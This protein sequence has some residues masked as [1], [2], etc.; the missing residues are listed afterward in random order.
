MTQDVRIAR[1]TDQMSLGATATRVKLWQKRTSNP[2][3]IKWTNTHICYK[4]SGVKCG[5]YRND[6]SFNLRNLLNKDTWTRITR[7]QERVKLKGGI[8]RTCKTINSFPGFRTTW[9]RTTTQEY[10]GKATRQ[11]IDFLSGGGSSGRRACETS[12]YGTS[13]ESKHRTCCGLA[14]VTCNPR[15]PSPSSHTRHLHRGKGSDALKL[16]PR[17]GRRDNNGAWGKPPSHARQMTAVIDITTR[18]VIN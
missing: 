18:A 8:T 4:I 12:P 17:N 2:K 11:D 5:K 3:N 7:G 1:P 15:R 6:P 14:S 10:G 16:L 13:W 9:A